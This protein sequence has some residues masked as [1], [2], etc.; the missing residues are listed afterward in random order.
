MDNN[1]GEPLVNII[2]R[3]LKYLLL[4]TLTI[5]SLVIL[6]NPAQFYMCYQQREKYLIVGYILATV[7]LMLSI[8]FDIID[9]NR[10]K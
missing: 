4:A 10:S 8:I 7:A 3:G 9:E 5:T 2:L 6:F 1:S